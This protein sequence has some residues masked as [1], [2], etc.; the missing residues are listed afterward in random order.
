M[1]KQSKSKIFLT[2]L[3]LAAFYPAGYFY[4]NS[5]KSGAMSTDVNKFDRYPYLNLPI[6]YFLEEDIRWGS[7]EPQK[8]S[9]GGEDAY[10][11]YPTTDVTLNDYSNERKKLKPPI[12]PYDLDEKNLDVPVDKMRR[13][14]D[15]FGK[16]VGS[17]LPEEIVMNKEEF[18][19]DGDGIN[20]I[21]VEITGIDAAAGRTMYAQIIKNSEVIFTTGA[22]Y[23]K[24][25]STKSGNGFY[26][27]WH[28]DEHFDRGECC[29][30]G[31]IKTRFVYENGKFTPVYEQEVAYVKVYS[32][33]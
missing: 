11:S 1:L 7:V 26:I 24:I 14:Y 8:T 12:Y 5:R 25:S 29:P 6:S 10:Q 2:F 20:E 22:R 23:P 27:E 18:D 19:V 32:P 21:I 28:K 13:Y 15:L 31:H 17:Y 3:V 9:F 4:S 30:A 33:E 16:V